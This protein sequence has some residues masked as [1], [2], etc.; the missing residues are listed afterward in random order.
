MKTQGVESLS[1]GE[2]ESL[3]DFG[4]SLGAA[5]MHFAKIQISSK[6]ATE[7]ALDAGKGDRTECE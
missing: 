4:A 7:A 2:R 3:K 5:I 1:H 6:V